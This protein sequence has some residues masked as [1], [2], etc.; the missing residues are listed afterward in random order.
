MVLLS[1]LAQAFS[2]D[3]RR[4][5]VARRGAPLRL[6][7]LLGIWLFLLP[8]CLGWAQQPP[9]VEF[10]AL[11]R[12]VEMA[13]LYPDQKTFADSIPD[14]S[15]GRIM[16]E[17]EKVRARPW[18]DLKKFVATHFTEPPLVLP[19]LQRRRGQAVSSYINEMW[20]VL[21]R[22]PDRPEHYSSRLPLKHPYE[23]PGGRF[24][25]IYYWDS[26][27]TMLGLIQN[28]RRELARDMLANIGDLIARYRHMP[29]GN[30][31]YYLSRSQ[32]PFFSA[33]VELIASQDGEGIYRTY[34]GEL[35]AEYDYWMAGAETL[36]PGRAFRRV[37]R[38]K[39]GTL[40]NRYWDDR[41]APR[42]ESYREDVETARKAK[43]PAATIY[44]ELRAAS[45]SGWDFSSRWLVDDRDLSTIHTTDFA[46]V[47]LNALMFQMEQVLARAYR[48]Q[49]DMRQARAFTARAERRAETI[50]R[51][52]WN[53]KA[54]LFTD[55]LWQDGRQSP[56]LSLAGVLPL[57]FGLA[58]PDQASQ[59]A[60]TLKSRF[61][62]R[63]GLATTLV[64][65]GQQWDGANGWAPLE[66]MAIEGLKVY[67]QTGL[68]AAIALRWIEEDIGSYAASGLLLEKYDVQKLPGP[69][70]ASGGGGGEYALQV[71]FGWTNGALARLMAEYP[72]AARIAQSEYPLHY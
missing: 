67:G 55:Y 11:Y 65:S 60:K 35:R 47:D 29:N 34:L 39:D 56:V 24:R 54:G 31:S 14:A 64:D 42:D 41:A 13:S 25:E 51:L 62:M 40:L 33:M 22:K 9:S 38:L 61:M 17:Y 8:P 43:R 7:G 27:F 26:Y 70:Q 5:T 68:A 32:P 23:V 4:P 2:E 3:L 46:P 53:G 44:R 63:G 72:D 57:Y 66:Y 48:L 1:R 71:G 16:A 21:E 18:F 58:T 69:E 52:M 49:G 50:R 45:E 37:V 19:P 30:R 6:V 59:T 36:E 12:A 28:G 20:N 10:G 15:P